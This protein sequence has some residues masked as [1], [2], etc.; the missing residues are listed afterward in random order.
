MLIYGTVDFGQLLERPCV[1]VRDS[2]GVAILCTLGQLSFAEC[3]VRDFPVLHTTCLTLQY[4]M[5]TGN[6]L[7]LPANQEIY[8]KN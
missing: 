8:K 6:N 4:S 5:F 1:G 3:Q 2:V 7:R